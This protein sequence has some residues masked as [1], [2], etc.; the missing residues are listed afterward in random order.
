MQKIMLAMHTRKGHLSPVRQPH[1]KMT[2]TIKLETQTL[3][4]GCTQ[5]FAKPVVK[6]AVKAAEVRE[7]RTASER[8][9]PRFLV[10]VDGEKHEFKQ[11]RTLEKF[12]SCIAIGSTCRVFRN[13]GFGATIDFDA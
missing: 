6:A 3:A 7:G 10:K 4:N 13:A 1:K 8:A 5:A 2:T 12:L 11:A 9:M